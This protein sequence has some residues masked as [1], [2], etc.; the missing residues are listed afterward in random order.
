MRLEILV[1]ALVLRK[2]ESDRGSAI[3]SPRGWFELRPVAA[4]SF[5]DHHQSDETYDYEE[6]D[7]YDDHYREVS[8][9]DFDTHQRYAGKYVG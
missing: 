9:G 5:F 8:P 1:V 2:C 6:Q 4:E 7:Y 3:S